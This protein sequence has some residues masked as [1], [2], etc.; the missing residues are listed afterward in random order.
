MNE[1]DRSTVSVIG[2]TRGRRSFFLT[3]RHQSEHFPHPGNFCSRALA[4]SLSL[5]FPGVAMAEFFERGVLS[6]F[7]RLLVVPRIREHFQ[8]FS[9]KFCSF[10]KIIRTSMFELLS[11][12]EIKKK[13]G[14]ERNRLGSFLLNRFWICFSF[15]SRCCFFRVV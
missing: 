9:Q 2:Q 1:G 13:K 4:R 5:F 14:E 15:F 7:E 10:S 8:R 11:F 3:R 12:R 6:R